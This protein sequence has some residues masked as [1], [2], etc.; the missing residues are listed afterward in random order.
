[1]PLRTL[2]NSLRSFFKLKITMKIFCKVLKMAAKAD[3]FKVLFTILVFI[4]KEKSLLLQL[5]GEMPLFK[6]VDFLVENKGTDFTKKDVAEGAEIG[7]ASLFNYWPEIEK[8]QIVKVTR[9]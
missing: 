3:F 5:T 2:K 9:Q 6:I 1:M 7:R 4:M 8:R